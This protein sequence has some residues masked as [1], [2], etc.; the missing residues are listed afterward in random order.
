[1]C[2]LLIG[3]PLESL[4]DFKKST[5]DLFPQIFD[6]KHIF[7]AI[8]KEFPELKHLFDVSSLQQLFKA[9]QS[10][11]FNLS[12]QY[13]PQITVISDSQQAIE[14]KPHDAAF[15]SYATGVGQLF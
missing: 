12:F 6:T 11:Q 5:L 1:M 9:V 8:K 10:E 7:L 3:S 4:H 13:Q 14:V 2:Q 15:D